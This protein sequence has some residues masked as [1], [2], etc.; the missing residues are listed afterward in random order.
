MDPIAN[1]LITMKNASMV[2]K[3]L[4]VVP[5]SKIKF[6]IAECLKEHGFVEN[7]SKKTEK[8]NIPV[9]EIKLAYDDKGAKI[10]DVVRVSKPSRRVYSGVKEIRPV[11]NGHGLTVLSTPK[12]ILSDKQARKEQVGGEVLFKIW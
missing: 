11:K 6:S 3:D 2:S 7:I 8:N 4:V 5:F 12:G 1:M 9:I 10:K